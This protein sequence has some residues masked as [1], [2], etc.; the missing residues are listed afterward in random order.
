MRYVNSEPT[1]SNS[2]SLVSNILCDTKLLVL[3]HILYVQNIINFSIISY[4][5]SA[6]STILLASS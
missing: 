3:Y 4:Y 2:I 6:C 5:Q 1:L